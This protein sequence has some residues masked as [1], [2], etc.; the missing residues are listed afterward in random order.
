MLL[1]QTGNTNLQRFWLG[2]SNTGQTFSGQHETHSWE[3]H[4]EYPEYGLCYLVRFWYWDAQRFDQF[5]SRLV[6]KIFDTIPIWIT[7]HSLAFW[8][9]IPHVCLFPMN[10]CFYETVEKH[11]PILLWPSHPS[12]FRPCNHG[13][14]PLNQ[15][16]FSQEALRIAERANA[17]HQRSTWPR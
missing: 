10:V 16:K 6:S 5:Q 13:L 12:I 2:G 11:V 7:S 1:A 14:Y 3:Y 8:L 4:Q 15:R 9:C 17:E